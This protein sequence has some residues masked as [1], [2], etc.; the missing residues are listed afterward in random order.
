MNTK[1]TTETFKEKVGWI[2]L[3]NMGSVMAGHLCK[4]GVDVTVFNRSIS[5]A[6]PLRTLGAKVAKDINELIECDVLF[7]MLS[8]GDVVKE[9]LFGTDGIFVKNGQKKLPRVVVEC[10]SIS[11]EMSEELRE[12]L[13]KLDIALIASPPSG[14]PEV[15]A[16]GNTTFVSSGPRDTF[17]YIKPLLLSI[18][19]SANYVGDGELARVAKICHNVWLGA[20][21]QSLAEVITLAQKA[22]LSRQ[23]FL[24]FLNNSALGSQ[25]TKG[26]TESWVKMD[27]KAGFSPYLMRKDMDL[28]LNLAKELEIPMPLSSSA[29]DHLQSLMNS[30][31]GE[32][33]FTQGLFLQQS[34]NSGL[35]LKVENTEG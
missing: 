24:A 31:F 17:E 3:G 29:R 9:V 7:T 8:T 27:E 19:K 33:D 28:G 2:G 13:S 23:D 14:N 11:V 32:P 16:S 26:R 22:G 20:I 18:G 35:A 25:F 21:S 34:K 1:T 6:E 10:S 12:R 4:A 5:K 30:E 15:V